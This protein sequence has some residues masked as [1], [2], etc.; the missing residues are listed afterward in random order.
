MF[1]LLR[2]IFWLALVLVVV[3]LMSPPPDAPEIGANEAV[4]AAV[5]TA[6]DVGGF[7]ER[8][9]TACEIGGKAA[10]VFGQR[11]QTGAKILFD[12]LGELMAEPKEKS[13]EQSKQQSKHTLKEQSK[14]APKDASTDPLKEQKQAKSPA[15]I[16]TKLPASQN[17]LKDDDRKPAWR[18]GVPPKNPRGPV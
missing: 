11:A 12:Y 2:I 9:P 13:K 14:D 18:G 5:A 3:S 1:F 17:T 7:C 6:S 8:Q 15:K 10:I 16:P 4:T